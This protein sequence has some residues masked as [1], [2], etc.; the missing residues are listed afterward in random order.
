MRYLFILL[1]AGCVTEGEVSGKTRHEA[2]T[3]QCVGYCDLSITDRNAEVT[4]DGKVRFMDGSDN[5]VDTSD[6][7]DPDNE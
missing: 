5:D 2:S 6:E 3:L 1:L 4:A 7:P